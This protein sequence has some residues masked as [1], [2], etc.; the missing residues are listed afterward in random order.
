MDVLVVTEGEYVDYYQT[1]LTAAVN[2]SNV[3][4]VKTLVE[5]GANVE[6]CLIENQTPLMVAARILNVEAT[7]ILLKAGANVNARVEHYGT[8]PLLFATSPEWYSASPNRMLEEIELLLE[9]GADVNARNIYGTSALMHAARETTNPKVVE[10]LLKAGADKNARD[11]GG[12][13]VIDYLDENQNISKDNYRKV[14][15]LLK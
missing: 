4:A 13:R 1:P 9:A 2:S 10:A 11:E 15:N 3:E 7:K 8:S 5:A 6:R 12:K 14:R